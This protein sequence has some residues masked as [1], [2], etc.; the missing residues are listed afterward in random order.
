[1]TGII[2]LRHNGYKDDKEEGLNRLKE[3][4]P[5]ELHKE[6]EERYNSTSYIL[7]K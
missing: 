6:L 1:M 3:L 5:K 4:L 7:V 2:N